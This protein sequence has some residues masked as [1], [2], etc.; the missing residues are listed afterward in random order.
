[1]RHPNTNKTPCWSRT[2]RIHP[3]AVQGSTLQQPPTG[4][5]ADLELAQP[6]EGL[7]TQGADR[8]VVQVERSQV[9]AGGEGASG[10]GGEIVGAQPQDSQAGEDCRGT[11]AHLWD[12]R[13]HTVDSPE[14]SESTRAKSSKYVTD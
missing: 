5:S 3:V 9:G 10:E 11:G 12:L 14:L 1:M 13:T 8:I 4:T 7:V 6:S 2:P